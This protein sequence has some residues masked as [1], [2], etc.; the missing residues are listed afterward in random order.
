MCP[1]GSKSAYDR[2]PHYLTPRQVA[3]RL[4]IDHGKVLGWIH[5]GELRAAN[6]ARVA[7]GRP[8]WRISA[9]SLALFI[10]GREN[11]PRIQRVRR[12]RRVVKD[13]FSEAVEIPAL[14]RLRSQPG[15]ATIARD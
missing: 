12:Q 2:F 3:D 6:L 9:E 1:E 4:G 10:A 8:R 7:G 14:K 5:S 13:Y 11:R 15:R